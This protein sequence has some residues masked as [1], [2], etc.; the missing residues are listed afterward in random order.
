MGSHDAV[1]CYHF[2]CVDGIFSALVAR[3]RLKLT[4]KSLRFVPMDTSNAPRVES[5]LLNGHET[6]YILDFVVT[7][8]FIESLASIGVRVVIIDHH[9]TAQETLGHSILP[10][11]V[12][13]IFD[14]NKCAT[15]LALDFFKPKLAPHM[16][17]MIEFVED[18]DLWR[19]HLEDTYAF[20]AG[21]AALRVSWD[22]RTNPGVFDFLLSLNLESILRTGAIRHLEQN[23]A[24]EH[25]LKFAAR[26]NLSKARSYGECLFVEGSR[27]QPL[28][29]HIGNA[30]AD[31]SLKQGLR[32]IGIVAYKDSRI[33]DP[34]KIKVSFRS[35]E[36][37]DTTK[38]T[39]AFGGGGHKNASSCI[40]STQHF[41]N[42]KI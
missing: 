10:P 24:V 5:L 8:A 27:Y 14:V 26:V 17:K 31:Q 29:S 42:W 20:R 7:L 4:T 22:A 13:F 23:A 9:K 19:F 35:V 2:P 6:V 16:L 33:L 41:N 1:V 30:L 25:A 3:E 18:S 40:I 28:R 36:D 38:I 32:G 37:E 21:M 11:N 12:L 39:E 34:S 15:T